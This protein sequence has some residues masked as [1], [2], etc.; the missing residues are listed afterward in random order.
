MPRN[1]F[2]DIS[3]FYSE[4]SSSVDDNDLLRRVNA[5]AAAD[6]IAA[7][8][9][10]LGNNA[11][12]A[13]ALSRKE[14]RKQLKT[15]SQQ[16][17][18]VG[19]MWGDEL[20]NRLLGTK[21]CPY[22]DVEGCLAYYW[23]TVVQLIREDDQQKDGVYLISYPYSK[24]LY[25]YDTFALFHSALD[26]GRDL[27]HHLG[28][29][30]ALTIF[31][32]K[33]KNAPALFSPERH[34]PF[35]TAGLDFS[36]KRKQPDLPPDDSYSLDTQRISLERLFNSAAASTPSDIILVQG[37]KKVPL[38]ST[39]EVIKRTQRWFELGLLR[40]SKALQYADTVDERW[41]V[42]KAT[43]AEEAYADIWALIF[44]LR[45]VG[46]QYSSGVVSSIMIAP[47]FC[48]FNAPQW[49]TFA[50]TLNATLK[51][52]M[53]GKIFIEIFH[54]E[55]TGITTATNDLRRSPYPTILV[56]YKT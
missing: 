34:S 45:Q 8:Q 2:D 14:I 48:T 50:I 20:Y 53:D 52:L 17:G 25:T 39:D 49:R 4:D 51:R 12:T 30:F 35:P 47:S 42:S 3:R 54:A 46:G 44:E 13:S 29:D 36:P 24:A 37:G 15:W 23:S 7:I 11:D 18:A 41:F 16:S 22:A 9:R 27:C 26:L 43:I 10:L 38:Y 5:R 19:Q 1:Y 28:S 31:H 56:C 55:Y 21:V 40:P 33:Y 6:K 32:P